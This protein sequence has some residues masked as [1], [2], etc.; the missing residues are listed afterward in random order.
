MIEPWAFSFPAEIIVCDP[1]GKILGM[2]ETAIQNYKAVGGAALVGRNVFDHHEEPSRSQLRA[3]VKSRQPR[4]YTT[5]KAAQK[6]LVVIAPWYEAGAYA[7][8]T[9]QVIDLPAKLPNIV[10]D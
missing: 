4:I 9:L 7:G 1:D 10:K 6:K 8:F 2:N 5:Q 3:M